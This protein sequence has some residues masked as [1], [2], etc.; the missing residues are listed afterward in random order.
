MK[1][2]KYRAIPNIDETNRLSERGVAPEYY[3]DGYVY[4]YL[5]P[6]EDGTPFILGE[7]I[8]ATEEFATPMYWY[9]VIESTIEEVSEDD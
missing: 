3:K 2:K 6:Y 8:E 4:G 1:I 7:L 9:P 5:L